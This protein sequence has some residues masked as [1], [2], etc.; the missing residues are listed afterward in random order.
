MLIREKKL[1][2]NEEIARKEREASPEH[3]ARMAEGEKLHGSV[4][5]SISDLAR[6]HNVAGGGAIPEEVLKDWNENTIPT[7]AGKAPNSRRN[8]GGFRTYVAVGGKWK[9]TFN[10]E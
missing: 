1:P 5:K 8:S 3:K 7:F 9:P 2:K 10:K 4:Q 6:E